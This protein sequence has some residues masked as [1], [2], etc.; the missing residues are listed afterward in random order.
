MDEFC[1]CWPLFDLWPYYC[2]LTLLQR[3]VAPAVFSEY[4][5]SVSAVAKP[6]RDHLNAK[7]LQE[8]NCIFQPRSHQTGGAM[9]RGD[10]SVS[11]VRPLRWFP[12]IPV[13]TV[14]LRCSNTENIVF[15]L[16]TATPVM[17]PHHGATDKTAAT[18]VIHHVHNVWN[19]LHN[20]GTKVARDGNSCHQL[21][22]CTAAVSND[23][24]V[25]YQD[26][27][28]LYVGKKNKQANKK[29]VNAYTAVC[30]V[31]H[32]MCSALI[33]VSELC[34]YC[35]NYCSKFWKVFHCNSVVEWQKYQYIHIKL[36]HSSFSFLV[37]RIP[38]S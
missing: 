8:D 38:L 2:I 35:A 20:R 30:S 25:M 23:K 36:I 29:G 19:S 14:A 6:W 9:G 27:L 33:D 22:L 34:L 28:I 11:G 16:F 10:I 24:R 17:K 18:A 37:S 26:K 5:R 13:L 1:Q 31:S 4:S 12:I 7:I 21:L 3:H 32:S 15:S